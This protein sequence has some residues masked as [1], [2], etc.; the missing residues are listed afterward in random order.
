MGRGG[1]RGWVVND[2]YFIAVDG[3]TGEKRFSFFQE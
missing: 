3:V 2:V 1:G